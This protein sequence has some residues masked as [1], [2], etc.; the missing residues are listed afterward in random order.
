[1]YGNDRVDRLY[2]N[3]QFI[4]DKD[5]DTIPNIRQF[6]SLINK[7]NWNFNLRRQSTLGQFKCQTSLV[8]T[9]Q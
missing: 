6:L 7:W 2:F 1:M 3:D 9:L 8:R 5:V 4:L